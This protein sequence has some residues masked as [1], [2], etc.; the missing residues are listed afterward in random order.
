[1]RPFNIT[2]G[3]RR[4]V[5]RINTTPHPQFDYAVRRIAQQA[6]ISAA[7]AALIAEL[8]GLAREDGHD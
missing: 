3:D 1:M 4:K 8:L 5:V 6:R 7:Q 2:P